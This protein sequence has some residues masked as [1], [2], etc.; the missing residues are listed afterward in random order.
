MI[1]TVLDAVATVAVLTANNGQPKS[2]WNLNST[3]LHDY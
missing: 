1:V 3:F 2:C